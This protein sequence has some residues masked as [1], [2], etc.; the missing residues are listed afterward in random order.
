MDRRTQRVLE[1]DKIIQRLAA[2]AQSE[3]GKA[4]CLAL[5][6]DTRKE[7]VTQALLETLEAENVWVKG[8]SNPMQNFCDC[9]EVLNRC[10]AGASA[11]C[12]E[13]L[14]I[15]RLMTATRL[16]KNR[17]AGQEPQ[18]AIAQWT[19]DLWPTK[20]LE[21]EVARCI[22]GKEESAD[23]ASED[24]RS[25][26]RKL[27]RAHEALRERLNGIVTSKDYKNMIQDAIVTMRNGRY[28][29]PIKA[30][31]AQQVAGIEHDRS[32]TGATVFI[33][34]LAV[35]QANNEIR[36]LQIQ[37]AQEMERILA[38][39]SAQCGQKREAL[40]RNI[41]ALSQLDFAFAKAG[42][43]KEMKARM[44]EVSADDKLELKKARHPLIP[45]EKVVPIDLVCG[46]EVRALIVTGPNTGGKT[47]TL[48]TAGLFALMAQS[49][50]FLP[51]EKAAVPV[52]HAVYA[53]IGDEQSIEQSLSTF[54]SHMGNIARI[55]EEAEPGVLVLLDELGAGTDPVE[56]AALAIAILEELKNKGANMIA[57]THYSELKSFA[58]TAAGFLNAAMEF[59]IAS[60]RPTYKLIV[61]YAGS[62]N[63]FEISRRLGIPERI[64]RSAKEQVN[65]DAAMLENAI[66]KAE[67]LRI[68]AERDAV[69][70]Q[71][72]REA[73]EQEAQ[74][75]KERAAA[76]AEKDRKKA[77]DIL[78]KA[79]DAL[80]EA[81]HAADAAI[82]EAKQALKA[83]NVSEA[84]RALQKA[85]EAKKNMKQVP[86]PKGEAPYQDQKPPKDAEIGEEVYL[87]KF[88]CEATVLSKPNAKGELQVQAGLIKT[89][90]RLKDIRTIPKKQQAKQGGGF[91]M[92]RE[93]KSVK[94]EI[95]VRGLTVEEA[96]LVVDQHIDAA[97]LSGL[98]TLSV[99]HGKGTGAL[100][101]G[102]QSYLKTHPH[103]KSMRLGLY[104]EGEDGVTVLELK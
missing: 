27:K 87:L 30:E 38:A 41:K 78:K 14:E 22:K 53:D 9:T 98:T 28:V 37:E 92:Q 55:L 4:I 13:L 90:V 77:N 42:L 47:V 33:E 100:R 43:A 52:Y 66:A 81:R 32:H 7:R 63:A 34:P 84:E 23:D 75:T 69:E 85:R 16:V 45:K 12:E 35:L 80:H 17:I 18:G 61:G 39:L 31:Y 57:T 25:I 103:V 59:D 44:P 91:R 19:E 73:A 56:G 11:S 6:P 101:A 10:Q 36:E 50:L 46:Q 29:V 104:G 20:G 64:I 51:A 68:Q 94:G 95:D 65:Q 1:Y 99:I 5:A 24:L 48:K 58:M 49:G 21:E 74:Q 88:G 60:L 67:Q 96:S 97:V 8:G 54:S 89:T 62:S 83:K 79:Q 72:A 40:T 3:S 102:L 76:Q 93:E 82:E 86:Q 2:H 15:A 70:A 26:R 71:T